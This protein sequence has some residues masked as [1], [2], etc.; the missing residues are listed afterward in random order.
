MCVFLDRSNSNGQVK[1]N[2][3][4]LML[5]IAA[6]QIHL[7]GCVRLAKLTII[8]EVE[9]CYKRHPEQANTA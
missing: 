2:G 6:A 8:V 1:R 5:D 7:T 9:R 3:K 4:G